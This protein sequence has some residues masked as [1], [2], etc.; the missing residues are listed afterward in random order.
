MNEHATRVLDAYLDADKL[1]V[2]HAVL[3][4]GRWGSGKTYFLQHVYEPG[5]IQR[6]AAEGRIHVPFLFVS[7]FGATSASEVE[8]R[9]YKT[10]CPAEAIAGAI[11]GTIALGI[12]EFLR[13]KD[14]TKGAVE[15]L[16]KKAIKRLNDFVFV[17]DDLERVEKQA[18]GEV[19][20]L[21]NSLVADHGRK[22]ILVTDEQKLTALIDGDTWKDQNEKIVGRRA[23]IQADLDSV[24]ANS[25]KGSPD[26]AAK[27]LMADQRDD[28]LG[29]SLASK[30]ENLRTVSWAM[31][32]AAAFADCLLAEGEI[33]QSHVAWSVGVV[34]ATTLWM[35]S[36]LLDAETLERL[37][38]LS[39]KLAVRTVGRQRDEP[40]DPQ[41]EKAKAFSDTFPS[42]SVDAPPLEYAFIIGFEKSGV[43][44]R[45]KVNTWVKSQFGFGEDYKEPSWRRLW[46]SHEK[47]M[48]ETGQA[49]LDLKDE[50]ARRVYVTHG[51]ILH[52]TGLAIRQW[53]LDDH[54]LTDNVDVVA[55][56]KNYIDDVAAQGLLERRPFDRFPTSFESFGSLGFI[57][58]ESEAFQEIFK[59]IFAR[60]Q[61]LAEVDLQA[62]AET[63]F[64]EAEAGDF[65]A[66]FKLIR[67]DDY[68]LSTKPILVKIPVE[69]LAA[70]MAQDVPML[71]AG[72]KL[73]AYRYHNARNGDPL[74]EEMKW[75]RDVYASVVEKLGKWPE[76]HRA[77][78]L[79]FMQ[80][81][82]RHYDRD[83]EP[84]FMIVPPDGS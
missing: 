65:D 31:H 35:R 66:L 48:N 6:M 32:N 30:V 15:K 81:L 83:K 44:D 41:L 55:F 11:A 1:A 74:L 52:A 36:G 51:E 13:V 8:M 57:S 10:A 76:P 70:F 24:I 33:P 54:S 4:E 53:E 16:G 49:L 9:I 60:S 47:P 37:P 2:P 59:Y 26:G 58:R 42:L 3:I 22:V 72:T 12:G 78:A 79:R 56:F 19:M 18:F 68:E 21:V 73:L 77:M 20:G 38:G 64:A 17:F 5:R 43:L 7:L 82:I 71:S 46:H 40:L 23:S 29:I 39:M 75:A 80:G 25:I 50:L 27:M 34:L 28:L 14:A 84:D 67:P 62:R 61:I 69:R 63:V 45:T